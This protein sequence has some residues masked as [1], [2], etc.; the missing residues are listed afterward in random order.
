MSSPL[1][2]SG[3]QIF[4]L[5]TGTTHRVQTIINLAEL[6]CNFL[7]A[8]SQWKGVLKLSE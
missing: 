1:L 3:E 4:K 8:D 5:K 6:P 7:L 2:F